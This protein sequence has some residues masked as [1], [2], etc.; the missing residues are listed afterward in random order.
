MTAGFTS[1]LAVLIGER[2]DERLGRRLLVPFLLLGIASVAVWRITSA[3][4]GGGDLRLYVLVQYLSILLV[5]LIV[6]LYPGPAPR[7][8]F[9]GGLI[10]SYVAAKVFEL[11]DR[12]I[13]EALGFVSGH[14]LKHVAAAMGIGFLVV[15]ARSRVPKSR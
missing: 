4:G 11:L 3:N 2:I 1:F 5:P 12:P 15:G 14:S 9:V 8:A 13:F 10:A 6:L 7:N